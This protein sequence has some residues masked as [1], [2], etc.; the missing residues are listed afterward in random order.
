MFLIIVEMS[1]QLH[2]VTIFVQ[3]LSQV[4]K[5]LISAVIPIMSIY[6]LPHGHYG[7]KGNVIN[8]RHHDLHHQPAST[9][10]RAG[11]I[12]CKKGWL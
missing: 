11:N 2:Y 8:L 7:Y 4:E 9:S 1:V 6:Q 12:D 5:M 3:G 10:K